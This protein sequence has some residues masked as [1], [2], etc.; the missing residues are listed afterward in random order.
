MK[1]HGSAGLS[2]R[3]ARKW[4]GRCRAEGSDGLMDHSSALLLVA[5]RT[6][7]GASR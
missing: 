2:D 1:L 3:T 5:N 6:R 7:T 4:L